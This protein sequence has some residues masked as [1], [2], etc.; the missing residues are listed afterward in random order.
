[1]EKIKDDWSVESHEIKLKDRLGQSLHRFGRNIKY[2]EFYP[3]NNK[4]PWEDFRWLAKTMTT[5]PFQMIPLATG[6]ILY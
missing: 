6:R 4:D 2:I 3:K 5:F 1:M